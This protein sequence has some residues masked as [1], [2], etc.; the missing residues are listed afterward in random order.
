MSDVKSKSKKVDVRLSEEGF[1]ELAMVAW[2]RGMNRS[3][4]LRAMIDDFI[5]RATLELGGQKMSWPECV[6]Y[7]KAKMLAE[8][9]SL[10]DLQRSRT[11]KSV[12]VP[13][14]VQEGLKD[15]LEWFAELYAQNALQALKKHVGE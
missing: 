2:A 11:K 4:L 7:A 1:E 10:D 8:N 6:A 3:E 13:E 5:Q 14:N 9:V 15:D 12:D